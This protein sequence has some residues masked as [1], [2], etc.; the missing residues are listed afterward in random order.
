MIDVK[1]MD[2]LRAF[3][4]AN[5]FSFDVV[6]VTTFK[7]IRLDGTVANRESFRAH[8][9]K[10]DE[11]VLMTKD[12]MSF[13]MGIADANGLQMVYWRR[14]SHP[15]AY[16][17]RF[18]PKETLHLVS[19]QLTNVVTYGEETFDYYQEDAAFLALLT[20]VKASTR[21]LSTFP[22]GVADNKA[23]EIRNAIQNFVFHFEN[24]I[25]VWE[26]TYPK[27]HKLFRDANQ[28]LYASTQISTPY[29]FL[30]VI[31]S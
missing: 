9:A 27:W 16:E 12:D 25:E 20:D 8:L 28:E 1:T 26:T 11:R 24:R 15:Y 19:E 18:F 3:Y 4:E 31:M 17:M 2:L 6:D 29:D 22:S 21:E 30:R 7:E 14:D 10:T 5:D 23:G 13:L